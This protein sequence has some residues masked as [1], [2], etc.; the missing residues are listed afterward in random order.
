MEKKWH[1][2]E[3]DSGLSHLL[4]D[5]CG[6]SGVGAN[7][8][9]S[10]GIAD[11]EAAKRYLNP[12]AENLYD[13]MS[14]LNMP[15]AVERL[16]QAVLSNEKI[17]IYG[18]YDTDGI[19][20]TALLLRFF[21][22]IGQRV[23]YYIPHRTDEGYGLKEEALRKIV[24][25]GA[26]LLITVDCGVGDVEEICLANQ[27]GMDVIVTDHHE[28]PEQIPENTIILNPKLPD[29]PYPY[30]DLSGVGVAYKLTCAIATHLSG[31]D[32][33]GSRFE[34]FFNEAMGLVVLGTVADVVPL[35]EENRILTSMGIKSLMSSENVGIHALIQECGLQDKTITSSDIAF[36]LSPRL[37]AAGRVEHAGIGVELLT[38]NSF[39]EAVKYA[40]Q[41][42]DRNCQRQDVE[43]GIL[44]EARAMIEGMEDH[45]SRRTFVLSGKDWHSGVIGIVASRLVEEY[46]RPV[47]LIAEDGDGIGRG[48]ARSIPGFHLFNVFN[49]CRDHLMSFG[50]HA[51]AAGLSIE[52][53]KIPE[54]SK[55]LEALGQEMLNASMLVPILRIDAEVMLSDISHAL[56]TQMAAFEPFGHMNPSPVL[57]A[58]GLSIAGRP[59][60]CGKNGQ[61]I[62]FVAAKDGSS[63]RAI[64]YGMREKVER[65]LKVSGKVDIAFTPFVN[66][67]QN[68]NEVEIRVVDI[69]PFE[70]W[71]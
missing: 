17:V 38:T 71:N 9:A 1:F 67:W 43:R 10:R 26:T 12:I 28:I 57:A 47:V 18:D 19:S 32:G 29:C 25:D 42:S 23:D 20:S 37:N 31:Q 13:P 52:S 35:V 60:P 65:V 55:Q 46:Y 39:T 33:L 56:V 58:R 66:T 8:L 7:I 22:M 64:A 34:R 49:S 44:E 27:L 68:R 4:Q 2:N 51:C 50:G 63:V 62:A 41:L 16:H 36:R 14:M 70:G 21:K 45:A 24:E 11:V 6:V 40:E 61:H 15:Q 59:Y 3:I 48:S 53:S 5:E 69:R 30:K 54:F